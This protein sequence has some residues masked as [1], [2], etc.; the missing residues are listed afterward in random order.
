MEKF[1]ISL[2]PS[3][4]SGLT[5]VFGPNSFKDV[6]A[7]R[8]YARIQLAL[9]GGNFSKA[10]VSSQWMSENSWRQAIPDIIYNNNL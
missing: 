2:T 7:A 6:D 5:V 9:G 4:P 3:D 8:D 1:L 10:T